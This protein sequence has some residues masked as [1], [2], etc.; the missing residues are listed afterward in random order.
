MTEQLKKPSGVLF[1]Q[2]NKTKESQPDHTGNIELSIDMVKQI[3]AEIKSNASKYANEHFKI[4]LA[5]WE[6]I[7]KSGQP[8]MSVRASIPEKKDDDLNDEIPF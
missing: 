4:D 7:A 2:K 3:V 8:Y 1:K 6:N 5:C